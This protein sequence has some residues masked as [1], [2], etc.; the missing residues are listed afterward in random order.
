M[1][2]NYTI[3]V[4]NCYKPQEVRGNLNALGIRGYIHASLA[5]IKF[6]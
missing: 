6:L 5:G 2:L 4:Q 1:N 3:N